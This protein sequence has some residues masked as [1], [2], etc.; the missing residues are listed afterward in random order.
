MGKT[1]ARPYSFGG[2][3]ELMDLRIAEPRARATMGIC[4]L[5]GRWDFKWLRQ[6]GIAGYCDFTNREIIL[7]RSY[8]RLN[9]E[10]VFLD[11]ICHLFAHALSDR[12]AHSKEWRAEAAELGVAIDPSS[13]TY[14]EL[15]RQEKIPDNWKPLG[16]RRE[17]WVWG[18]C[19]APIPIRVRHS[20]SV[21]MK[22]VRTG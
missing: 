3:Q 19:L 2:F 21:G 18:N 7:S 9:D 10:P 14:Q 15:L 22:Q 8:V 16:E 4:G 17:L 1:E 6:E 13:E 5:T 20:M 12:E 11:L